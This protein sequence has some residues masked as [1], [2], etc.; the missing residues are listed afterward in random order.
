MQLP[1]PSVR[2]EQT[3][4]Q[5]QQLV[6]DELRPRRKIVVAANFLGD[7]AFG[8]P[9]D[10][11]I[12]AVRRCWG[13]PTNAFVVGNVAPLAAA[14]NHPVLPSAAARLPAGCHKG[15]V[16]D[17]PLRSDRQALAHEPGIAER[18]HFTGETA[19]QPKPRAFLDVSV[20]CSD[21]EGF[22]KAI[23]EAM[24]VPRQVVA[25]R[26]NGVVDVVR[27]E[28][29]GP[30]LP[31]RNA[32]SLAEALERLY[33]DAALRAHLAAAGREF[34][35]CRHDRN[36]VVDRLTGLYGQLAARETTECAA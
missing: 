10:S 16:G 5:A 3:V 18:L 30:V 17:G 23:I 15:L 12:Q 28:Q 21:G 1:I 8:P 32:A 33:R 31:L 2:S 4:H 35:R 19:Q 34:V 24:A 14:K 13:V 36:T 26:I 6:T 29:T 11:T 25:T 7:H 22:P 27:Q 9:S 20:L